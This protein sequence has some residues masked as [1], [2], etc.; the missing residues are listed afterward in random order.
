MRPT[1]VRCWPTFRLICWYHK[2]SKRR[3]ENLWQMKSSVPMD[4]CYNL[5]GCGEFSPL[6]CCSASTLR[7]SLQL[8]ALIYDGVNG[9]HISRWICMNAIKHIARMSDPLRQITVNS[10]S[11]LGTAITVSFERE[12]AS[13]F[14]QF[15]LCRSHI[16]LYPTESQIFAFFLFDAGRGIRYT[17]H[18]FKKRVQSTGILR[19]DELFLSFFSVDVKNGMEKHLKKYSLR[20]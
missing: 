16:P 17:N 19:L 7:C 4:D 2:R 20:Q 15:S 9:F 12:N 3:W 6:F 10:S 18:T 1:P 14:T 13:G 11:I 8:K 5:L